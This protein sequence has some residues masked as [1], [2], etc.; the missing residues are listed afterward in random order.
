M[1]EGTY[2]ITSSGSTVAEYKNMLTANGLLVINQYL[3]NVVPDWAGSLAIGT[4]STNS[5]AST[6]T[7]LDYEILRFPVTLKA[8]RTVSGSNQMAL[9]ATIDP[10]TVFQ[11]YEFGIFPMRVNKLLFRDHFKITDF[12][13]QIAASSSWYIGSSPAPTASVSPTPRSGGSGIKISTG[14]TASLIFYSNFADYNDADSLDLLYYCASATTST[15]SITVYFSDDSTSGN[16]WSASGTIPATS[17]G[18]Y[19]HKVLSFQPKPDAFTDT[20][21][22]CSIQFAGS[23]GTLLLDHLKVT[24]GQAKPTDQ[25]LTSRTTSA[26]PLVT[27]VYGQP[28]EIEY[29]IQVT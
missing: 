6:T 24:T 8:Y 17:S 28:M 20:M 12:T 13:E 5:T 25:L 29:Y 2:R 11:A 27:K 15:S 7:A 3:A 18:T 14:Q 21:Y 4:L 16:V 10:E 1:I 26:S 22:S 19:T 9:K 23:G